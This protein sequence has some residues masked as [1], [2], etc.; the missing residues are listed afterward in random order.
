MKKQS[1]P[2]TE[3][4]FDKKLDEKF[5]KR[6]HEFTVEISRMLFKWTDVV[7]DELRVVIK[8]EVTQAKDEI[9]TN[10][11]RI[12]GR[13]DDHDANDAIRDNDMD[14]LRKRLTR[15]ENRKN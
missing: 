9:L 15:I 5:D 7:K 14:E 4:V 2:L 10:V 12:A 3:E 6:F 8:E 11:D 1:K 13:I